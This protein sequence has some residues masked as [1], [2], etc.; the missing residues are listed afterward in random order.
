MNGKNLLILVILAAIMVALAIG[1]SKKNRK[2]SPAAIGKY[3]FPSLVV[4]EIEKITVHSTEGTTT[5]ARIN[6]VWSV[7]ERQNYPANFEKIKEYLVKISDMKI[8]QVAKVDEAQKIKMKIVS[9][10]GIS[11]NLMH[12]A[13]RLLE[14]KGK[15]DSVMASLVIGE[16]RLKKSEYS[17]P[18]FP[19]YPDGQFISPDGGKNV[20]LV[21]TSLSEL[22]SNPKDWM[23]QELLNVASSD[24]KEISI[25]GQGKPAL[26]L[27][28][29]PG[30]TSLEVD[31]LATNEVTVESKMYGIESALSY[32]KFDDIADESLKAEQTGLAKPAVFKVITQKGEIYTVKIGNENETK[33]YRYCKIEAG[34]KDAEKHA[35]PKDDNEKK[36]VEEAAKER[37]E[38]EEKIRAINEKTGKWTY[39]VSSGK[40]ESMLSDRSVLVEKKKE[41]EKKNE[42]K[43]DQNNPSTAISPKDKQETPGQKQ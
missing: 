3:V 43:T 24:I 29:K 30:K 12:N 14:L 42:D 7:I 41:E 25:A 9:P 17:T 27:S 20:Y 38:L 35:K 36:R 33:D 6:D 4:D 16:A 34:L 19:G 8:G 39:M 31:G 40:F 22:P 1:T 32:F 18:D 5:V 23:D 15:G 37:K 10:A 2:S 28:K 11:S 21:N 13:G 26:T